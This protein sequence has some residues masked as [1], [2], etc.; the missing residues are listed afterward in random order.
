[1]AV[2]TLLTRQTIPAPIT[3]VWEFFSNPRNL[4]RITPQGMGF[5]TEAEGLPE[6]IRTGLMITHR[7]RPFLN[8]PITWLT[9]I[10]HVVE[11]QLFIDE[12]RVG[13]YAV[14]HHE[15]EF[16]D[17][18]GNRTEMVDRVTYVP[19]FG[20]LGELVHPWLIK[21]ELDRVFAYREQALRQ[22]FPESASGLQ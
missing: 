14:W 8:V 2:H 6:R 19:P 21:P 22:L 20:P 13:P 9:E 7:L 16:H 17:L 5:A 11:N 18:G 1:M 4:S 12:Q 3:Q 15:H 10:T